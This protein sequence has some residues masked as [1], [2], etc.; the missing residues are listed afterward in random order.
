MNQSEIIVK[1][2]AEGGDLTLYGVRT[3]KGWI[4]SRD[5]IDQSLLLLG[6][7]E[8]RHSSATVDSWEEALKLLDKYPWHNLSPREVHPEFR[9]AV[10]DAVV[11]RFKRENKQDPRRL[12]DWKMRCGIVDDRSSRS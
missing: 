2:G 6:E 5:V 3:E 4:F 11:A 8:I 12:P 10:F 9:Q 1:V 7:P